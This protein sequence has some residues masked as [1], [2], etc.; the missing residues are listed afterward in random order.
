MDNET[1]KKH[2]TELN[3]TCEAILGVKGQDYTIGNQEGDKLYN[4]REVGKQLGID[5]LDVAAIYWLKHVYAI[6]AYVKSKKEGSE[7]IKLRFADARNYIDLMYA[8]TQVMEGGND[9]NSGKDIQ[10]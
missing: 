8:I 9:S 4:F 10:G 1:F 2:R 5:T 6:L 3:L 7:P